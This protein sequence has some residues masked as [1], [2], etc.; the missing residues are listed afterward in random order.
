MRRACTS[1]SE[2]CQKTVAPLFSMLGRRLLDYLMGIFRG[3]GTCVY[4]CMLSLFRGADPN[5]SDF[6]V[7]GVARVDATTYQRALLWPN[8]PGCQKCDRN[9]IMSIWRNDMYGNG[10]AIKYRP[11][12]KTIFN[13]IFRRFVYRKP[14]I[15]HQWNPW[16]PLNAT[17]CSLWSRVV[18]GWRHTYVLKPWS[19]F[20]SSCWLVHLVGGS[21][22]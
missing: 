5:F 21:I 17:Q 9:S 20:G 1:S 15:L 14:T 4:K 19:E 18:I 22:V 10:G 12:G 7:C 3:C 11:T 16:S 2:E 13:V 6:H 8:W